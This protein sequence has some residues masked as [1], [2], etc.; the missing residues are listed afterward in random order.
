MPIPKLA[1]LLALSIAA[2]AGAGG[3]A[4]AQATDTGAATG[5]PAAQAAEKIPSETCLACH[6]ND[7]FGVEGPDGKMR[8]L[9]V[10]KEKFEQSVHG[11]RQCVEC[12]TNITEVPHPKIEVK[13]SCVRCHES[14]WQTAQSEG[15]TT[16]FARLG[17]VIRQIDKYMA[18]IHARPSMEDQSHT[19]ATCYDCHDAHYVYPPGSAI[20]AEWRL[21]IPKTCGKCHKQE[22]ADY[23]TS[24]HGRLVLQ[25]YN[26]KAAI[27][28]DCHT[29][30]DIENPVLSSTRLAITKNCGSCHQEELQTYMDTYHGQVNTLGYAYTAK[31][32]DC[33]GNHKIQRV[34][35]PY[36]TVY[37][38]NRLKTCQKCHATATAGFVTFEPHATTDNLER[39][40]YTWIA[41]K[42][43]IALLGGTF[44]FFW[45][46]SALWYYREVRDHLAM[47]SRPHVKTAELPQDKPVYYR[48]WSAMWRLA[49]LAFAIT[50]I[51][52]IFTGMTLFYADSF[53]APAVQR[54]FGG[55]RITGTV[56]RIFA[57]A[58]VA[59]F[60]AHLAYVAVRVGRNWRTFEWFGPYSMIPNL[61]DLWD[62]VGMFKWFLGFGPKP[63]FDKWTYWEKFDYWAPFWGVTI[64]GVSGAMIWFKTLT[65]SVLPGWVFNVAT[66]FHGEEAFLAAAFLFTVHFFNNHWRPEN[67]PLDTIMFTGVMPLE[68]FKREHTIEYNRLVQSGQLANY[69]VDAPSR[70]MTV[71]SK[72]L[73]F[74]LMAAGLIL[75]VL[76]MMGLA[77]NLT[78]GG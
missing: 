65:A 55:P 42:F 15:K 11:K 29:S 46:H 47:K 3:I 32:F 68:K 23:A 28:S 57:V 21:H 33:H 7:E 66:I 10:D 63:V 31:C 59:I 37:P 17:V 5:Q 16:E 78:G 1:A 36:S 19:N 74:V 76:I 13:V 24:V 25:D 6:G 64:I 12:H 26:P 45:T 75:L 34:N 60:F 61:Q 2:L 27:C 53:W 38:A 73:G 30:H 9:F 43:M 62:V 49:H 20:R 50:V 56:H 44:A 8:S 40:P 14:L 41:S 52:L 77:H 72:I 54:A 58:F 70:P 22:L 48:R 67:F 35:D 71:G 39:Y 51:A 18:S 4:R 69:L